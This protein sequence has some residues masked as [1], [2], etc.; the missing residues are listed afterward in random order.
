MQIDELLSSRQIPFERLSHL[1]A[2]TANRVAQILHIRGKDVAKCVVLKCNRGYF[3]AVLPAPYKIDLACI[4][5][6]LGEENVE[7]AA[8]EEIQQLFPDCEVG[9]MPPFGSL[10]HLPTYVD[11]SLADESRIVFEAQCHEEAIRMNYR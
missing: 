6:E 1:P 11:E 4:C 9:A 3:L 2:F 8:E 10:Y 5:R 7:M